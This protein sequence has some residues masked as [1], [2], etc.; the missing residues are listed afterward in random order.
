MRW[1][2]AC[3]PQAA[4]TA[5]A[6]VVGKRCAVPR[7]DSPDWAVLDCPLQ[8]KGRIVPGAELASPVTAWHITPERWREPSPQN[9]LCDHFNNSFLPGSNQR[10]LVCLC[11]SRCFYLITRGALQNKLPVKKHCSLPYCFLLL[12]AGK[13]LFLGVSSLFLIKQ[14]G[15]REEQR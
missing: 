10:K 15:E 2:A 5:L 3:A 6:F 1:K 11:V 8:P 12:V 7:A 9:R 4:R 13:R 14:A